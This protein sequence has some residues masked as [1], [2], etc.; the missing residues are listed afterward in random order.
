MVDG[1]ASLQRQLH[2][3]N[4]VSEPDFERL[5]DFD[6]SVKRGVANAALYVTDEYRAEVGFFRE[7]FLT[8]PCLL[9][10]CTY[11]LTKNATVLLDRHSLLPNQEASASTIKHDLRFHLS[12]D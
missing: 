1:R 10:V 2:V 6:Q 12:Y 9:A 11:P 3:G 5:G 7:F 4:Q 8:Q